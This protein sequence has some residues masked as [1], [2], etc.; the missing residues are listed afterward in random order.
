VPKP[1]VAATDA[2]HGTSG[3]FDHL[4]CYATVKR[5]YVELRERVSYLKRLAF[6]TLTEE[7][8]AEARLLAAERGM[9]STAG[10]HPPLESTTT[11]MVFVDEEQFRSLPASIAIARAYHAA[12]TGDVPGTLRYAQ[13]ALDPLPE[14]DLPIRRQ[15]TAQLGLAYWASGDLEAAYQTFSDSLAGNLFAIIH[16]AFALVDINMTLGHIHEAVN[17]CEHAL[18]LAAEQGEPMPMATAKCI[19]P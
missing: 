16:G 14:G 6:Y 3:F 5:A 2:V 13:R 1:Q 17:V 9:E 10:M 15:A 7:E 11:D 19:L 12:A 18:Q 4:V 8:A